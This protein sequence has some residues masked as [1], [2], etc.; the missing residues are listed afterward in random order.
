MNFPWYDSDWLINYLRAK[1]HVQER[2]PQ[3]LNDFVAAFDVLR[4]HSGLPDLV[5]AFVDFPRAD[6]SVV[7][8]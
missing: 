4:T 6:R 3:I 7:G 1:D 2:H 5:E 8:G